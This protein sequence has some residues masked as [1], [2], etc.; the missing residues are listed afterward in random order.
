MLEDGKCWRTASV[1]GR[2]EVRRFFY[3]KVREIIGKSMH[4]VDLELVVYLNMMGRGD[5]KTKLENFNVST[6]LRDF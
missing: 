6:N 5:Q 3:Y 2:L 4:T 1:G